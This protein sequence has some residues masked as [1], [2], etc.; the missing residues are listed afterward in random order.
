MVA[1]LFS[2]DLITALE[3][4]PITVVMLKKVDFVEHVIL[5]W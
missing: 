5:A 3:A 4:G 2:L 1:L